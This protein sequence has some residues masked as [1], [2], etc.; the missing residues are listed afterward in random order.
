ML[1]LAEDAG[2]VRS[3]LNIMKDYSVPGDLPNP[4]VI[5]YL[6]RIGLKSWELPLNFSILILQETR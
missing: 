4:P 5:L 6:N 2:D 1:I 3:L